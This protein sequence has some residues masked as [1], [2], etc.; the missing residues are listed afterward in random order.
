MTNDYKYILYAILQ[1][2]LKASW[3]AGLIYRTAVNGGVIKF[4]FGGNSPA[5]LGMKIPHWGLGAKLRGRQSEIQVHRKL[6]Q[7]ADIADIDF[8]CRNDQNLKI[9]TI[10]C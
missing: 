1:C 3:A 4:S 5:G 8:D 10:K 7:V 2:A 9:K 6:K